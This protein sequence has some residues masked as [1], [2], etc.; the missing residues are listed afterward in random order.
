MNDD[1]W[2]TNEEIENMW[3][4]ESTKEEKDQYIPPH[5]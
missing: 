1:F 5:S 2:S 4:E 3:F